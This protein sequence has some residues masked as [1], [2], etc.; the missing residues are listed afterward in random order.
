M[1]LCRRSFIISLALVPLAQ[2]TV[3]SATEIT[4]PTRPVRL[5]I[6]YPPGGAGDIVARVIGQWL[7]DRLGQ[8]FIVENRPGA[9]S[10]IAAEAV[11]KA[12]ADGYTLYWTTLANVMG[13]EVHG[14]R[15]ELVSPL[16]DQRGSSFRLWW[17]RNARI[18]NNA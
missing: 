1:L 10:M 15:M 16:L 5:V 14:G 18:L 17:P 12:L 3:T 11:A 4:Y 9:A 2:S 7:Q 6:G 8:P 13:V